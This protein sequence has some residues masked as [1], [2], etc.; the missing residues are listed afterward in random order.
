MTLET[1]VFLASSSNLRNKK[2]EHAMGAN[3]LQTRQYLLVRQA[4]SAEKQ[5]QAVS[6]LQKNKLLMGGVCEN[7]NKKTPCQH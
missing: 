4:T 3:W 7:G 6:N 1:M 2:A 5:A